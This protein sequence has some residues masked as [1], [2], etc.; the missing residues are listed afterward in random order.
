[1]ATIAIMG[2]GAVGCYYGAMLALAGE[3]VV[4]IG[5]DALVRAV[6]ERGLLLDK[7]GETLRAEVAASTDP[8]AV[9]GA[10]LVLVCVKSPDTERA[11]RDLAPHLAPAATVLSL[12]NGIGNTEVLARILPNPV[13]PAVVYVAAAMLAPGHV[14]H[15]GR[16]EL[17]LPP[18]AEDIAARL[19][20]AGIR[21]EVT[22]DAPVALWSK[23]TLN[24][25]LNAVSALT[26]Q[27]YG[28]LAG[29][30][31]IVPLLHALTD[32]CRAV[33][34]A[35]GVTLPP[36]MVELVEGILRTMPAQLSS[37]AQDLMAG[38]PTEIGFL[39]AEI[40]RRGEALGIPVPLNAAMAALVRAA[41]AGSQ[42]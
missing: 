18:G 37:T 22:A 10:D 5:R 11:A 39:N 21:C 4:L 8:A 13:F 29:V 27:P 15:N 14:A 23:L 1:M 12:Q 24:C 25:A 38:K 17:I 7:G 20:A 30:E 26:R 42:A 40:A 32:E 33:A 35:S 2:A 6:A 19:G 41:E 34:A 36:D 28:V 16:G 9:A 3:R 31:G